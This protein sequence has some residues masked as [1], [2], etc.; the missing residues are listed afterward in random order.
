MSQYFISTLANSDKP[1]VLAHLMRL[2]TNDRYMRFFAAVS[3]YVLERYVE[4][5]DLDK[6]ASFG[7]YGRD[8]KTLI[9][10]AHVGA[11]EKTGDGG[12]IA[13][14]GISVDIDRRGFGLARKLMARTLVY[15]RAS[16]IGTLY[17]SCLRENKA[18]Q[19]LAKETGLKVVL[20]HDEAIADLALAGTPME[21]LS[22]IAKELAFNQISIFDKCYRQN[23]AMVAAMLGDAA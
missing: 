4:K 23:A 5:M 14:L 17:M 11:E 19:H 8:G 12:K 10:F 7:I 13:E 6:D 3:D 18:M 20:D 21:K 22:N 2:N 16:S 9:A 15:C 1:A